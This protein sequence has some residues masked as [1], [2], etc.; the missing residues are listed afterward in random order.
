[1]N[2]KIHSMFR[3]QL[4]FLLE[5]ENTLRTK[6]IVSSCS[7]FFPNPSIKV[8][9]SKERRKDNRT[10]AFHIKNKLKKQ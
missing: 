4:H 9:C 10:D 8:H 3:N 6:I 7:Y 5:E 2:K 1:M